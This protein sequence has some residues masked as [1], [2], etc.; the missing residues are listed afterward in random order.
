MW[1]WCGLAANQLPAEK[2]DLIVFPE[3]VDQ[4]EIDL[5]QQLCPDAVIAGATL[6]GDRMR[7][8]IQHRSHNHIDYQKV[9]SDGHSEGGPPPTSL[10]I[11]VCDTIA[12]GLLICMDIQEP[13]LTNSVVAGLHR[14]TAP[15]KVLC[16][17][18]EM[19]L[20]GGWFSGQ[21]LGN[22]G[23]VGIHVALSNNNARYGEHRIRNFI[24][25]ATGQK[26][27]VQKDYE[28]IAHKFQPARHR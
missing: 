13:I 21:T 25:D 12:V 8:V 22:S 24:A 11:Y 9:R 10:P 27:V 20:S 14:A 16:I 28:A 26:V 19:H 7:G 4:S 3:G 15:F 6:Q 5:A 2:P 23:W 17:P 1:V 18:A